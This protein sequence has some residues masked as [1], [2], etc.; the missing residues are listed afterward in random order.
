MNPTIES[1]Q[2]K[3]HTIRIEQDLNPMN[4]RKEWD[5]LGIMLCNHSRYDLGDEEASVEEIREILEGNRDDVAVAL[6]LYLYDHSGIT[7]KTSPFSCRWD[8][9]MVGVIY[10]TKEKAFKEYD[11]KRLTKAFKARLSEYLENEVKVYDNYLTGSVWGYIVEDESGQ[12]IDSCW[13]YYGETDEAM[14]EGRR[15]V[16]HATTEGIA[17]AI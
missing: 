10:I 11:K 15:V 16:D 17:Y 6:P 1:E 12:D 9:G 4:P 2:Y 8:S 3:G 7:M 5:N 14:N 13:G